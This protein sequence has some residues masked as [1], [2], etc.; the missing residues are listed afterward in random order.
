MV[1]SSVRWTVN[2]LVAND[3]ALLR[4]SIKYRFGLYCQLECRA[5]ARLIFRQQLFFDFS[6]TLLTILVCRRT[7][8][9]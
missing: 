4:D 6:R 3:L 9:A 8:S 1:V 2:R 5:P 7:E